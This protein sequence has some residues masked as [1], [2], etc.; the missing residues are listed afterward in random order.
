[1]NLK[2]LRYPQKYPH[3]YKAPP[4]KAWIE[5]SQSPSDPLKQGANVAHIPRRNPGSK[6][7]RRFWIPAI[8]DTFIPR[9]LRNRDERQHFLQADIS[10]L[11]QGSF[12]IL[13]LF[14]P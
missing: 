1:M 10:N 13:L 8:S 9:R 2:V 3:T 4:W 7:L 6:L 12:P 5:S 14:I 11:R